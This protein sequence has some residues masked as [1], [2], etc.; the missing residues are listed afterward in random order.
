M[1]ESFVPRQSTALWRRVIIPPACKISIKLLPFQYNC[2]ITQTFYNCNCSY[3]LAK[4]HIR[5]VTRHEGTHGSYRILWQTITMSAVLNWAPRYESIGVWRYGSTS[6]NP[7]TTETCVIKRH[8]Q[9]LSASER[10]MDESAAFGALVKWYW[11][12]DI[13]RLTQIP[14]GGDFKISLNDEVIV[15]IISCIKWETLAS[16]K[17]AEPSSLPSHCCMSEM[18]RVLD[19]GRP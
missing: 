3:V 2:A 12:G 14:L 6:A 9:Q 11:Q 16:N 5:C 13:V 7:C 17:Q 4:L 8:C 15:V 18:G 1:L 19:E 10:W